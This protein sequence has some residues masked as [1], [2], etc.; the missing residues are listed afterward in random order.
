MKYFQ[1]YTI[2]G[3]A[4]GEG[5]YSS[6]SYNDAT[7]STSTNTNTGGSTS[8]GGGD[9]LANTGFDAL[10]IVTIACA[11][12]FVGLLIRIMRR[13]PRMSPGKNPDEAQAP[14]NDSVN[15]RNH[16]PQP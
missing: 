4:Y 5:A 8:T 6:C 1:Y 13:K 3:Q 14:K 10:V 12:I 16:P 11:L 2:F 9:G 15:Q 7:C